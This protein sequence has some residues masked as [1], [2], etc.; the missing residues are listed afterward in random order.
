MGQETNA[1]HALLLLCG[2]V[3]HSDWNGQEAELAHLHA[4]EWRHLV[5]RATHHGLA[6]LASRNLDWARERRAIP[7]PVAE[8]LATIRLQVLTQNLK[9]RAAARQVAN[10]LQREGIPFI[11]L[12][13]V[14]LAEET[15][16]DLSLRGFNDFDVMVPHEGVEQTY[17]LARELGYGL[18]GF[19]NIQD[20]IR[21]G[22]HAAGM[23]RR[24]GVGLDI[25]W[26]LGPD[27]PPDSAAVVWKN[28]VAAPD[29]ATLPGLRLSPE[30]SLVHLAKHFHTGQYVLLKPLVDFHFTSRTAGSID[31]AALHRAAKALN[32]VPV[33]QIAA[34][35]AA[36]AIG[37]PLAVSMRDE[38]A[39][40]WAVRVAARVL[41]DETLVN[42]AERSRIGNW[43]R[44]LAA[45][46]GP[47]HALREIGTEFFPGPFA[48][49][50]FF[51][52]PYRFGMYP[53]YYWRQLVKVL[54]LSNK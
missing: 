44:Y 17:R 43:L 25:H 45:A 4:K 15:Y 13:G 19:T 20:W 7:V 38:S 39:P 16:G 32:L 10:A 6:G 5:V 14:A 52:A 50:R 23:M 33:V 29:H 27:L 3:R 30:M 31:Q 22:A 49:A 21:A 54:T 35:V 9:R 48:L 2:V 51:N 12:K 28:C 18:I 24:D 46:G 8:A 11:V 41:T 36:R 26:T 40:G 53:L 34:V 37:T 47:E 1:A 42:A